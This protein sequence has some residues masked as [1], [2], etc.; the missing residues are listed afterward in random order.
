MTTWLYFWAYRIYKHKS[1]EQNVGEIDPWSHFFQ[2][3]MTSDKL[4]VI[5]N[6]LLKKIQ[7]GILKKSRRSPE[8]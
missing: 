2:D 6:N 8:E 1:F 4:A 3:S 5:P 7:T